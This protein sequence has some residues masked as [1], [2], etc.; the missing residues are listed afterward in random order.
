MSGKILNT[1]SFFEPV[2][3]FFSFDIGE[4]SLVGKKVNNVSFMSLAVTF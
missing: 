3:S 1:E 4:L 2:E